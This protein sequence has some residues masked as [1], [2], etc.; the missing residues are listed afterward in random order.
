MREEG[1]AGRRVGGNHV[2][3][4]EEE[5]GRRLKMNMN[6]IGH[7]EFQEDGSEKID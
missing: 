7:L 1:A 3:L 2:G 6:S 5:N 4:E